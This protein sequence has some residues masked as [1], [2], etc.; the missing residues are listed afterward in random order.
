MERTFLLCLL[1][2]SGLAA[3]QAQNFNVPTGSSQVLHWADS[4]YYARNWK[5]AKAG[6]LLW[7]KNPDTSPA[8]LSWNRLGYCNH[9]LGLYDE[10]LKDYAQSLTT[11]P[12]RALRSVVEIRM[13]EIFS[14]QH[15]TELSQQHMDSAVGAGFSNIAELD[16]S[17]DLGYIKT[18]TWFKI[19]YDT[20]YARAWPCSADEKARQFDFWIGEW[21]VYNQAKL[22]SGHSLIQRISGGCAILENYTTAHTYEGKSINYYEGSIGKWE[23]V[24]VGSGGIR[25]PAKDIQHFVNGEYRDGAMRFTFETTV[26]GQKATGNFIFYNLGPDKVRQY[27]ETSVDG[28]KTYQL[29]YDLTYIRRK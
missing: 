7:L 11:H 22:L 28:G 23:Q 1:L 8:G 24:W 29:G 16:T 25:D 17:R 2:V 14:V 20:V 4:M 13:S 19:L 6:Y 10:A 21:D 26:N 12:S 15:K 9:N 27:Q 18:N 3:L 5:E